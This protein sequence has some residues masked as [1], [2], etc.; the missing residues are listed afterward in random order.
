MVTNPSKTKKSPLT[1]TDLLK[2]EI[3]DAGPVTLER[4]MERALTDPNYGY[5]LTKKPIGSKGDFITAPEVSQLF[6]EMIALW[7]MDQILRSPYAA[8]KHL[9]LIECGPGRG[10][11]IRDILRVFEKIPTFSVAIDLH[12]LEVN[13]D[14]RKNLSVLEEKH[15]LTFHDEVKSLLSIDTTNPV[16]LIA[17]EFLDVFPIQQ[18]VY[19]KGTWHAINVTFDDEQDRFRP[20]PESAIALLPPEI[21]RGS[22]FKQGDIL[23]YSPQQFEC[24]RIFEHILQKNG[25]FALLIDYGYTHAPRESSLQAL[26]GHQKVDPF[27]NPGEADLTSLI[28]FGLLYDWCTHSST[29]NAKL[30]S[31]GDFLEML[32]IK[33]RVEILK[34]ISSQPQQQAIDEALHRLTHSSAMGSLFKVLTLT[35]LG[36]TIHAG[37]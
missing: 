17:N 16:L 25:G 6:G 22:D 1:L 14:F 4:Y 29:L 21:K 19:L 8:S 36:N 15:P 35:S 33:T 20:T 2:Q 18:F 7:F 23:E 26:K 12:F 32:G 31:Q 11:L 30:I 5:Y 10:T 13:P 27:Q 3:S 37:D 9:T 24:L 34:K 28:N